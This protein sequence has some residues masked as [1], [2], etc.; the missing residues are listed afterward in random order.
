MVM[1]LRPL[2]KQKETGSSIRTAL[3]LSL[4]FG[5]NFG[6]MATPIG[7][8][9]NAI[10]I[11]AI[12]QQ[13]PLTFIQWMLIA[14]P[15]T[16][17][18]LILTFL[19]LKL[20]YPTSGQIQ[21]PALQLD[22][23]TYK[24]HVVVAIFFAAVLAWLLEPLHGVPAAIIAL[25]VAVLLFGS[26]LLNKSD[27]GKIDWATLLLIAGGLTLGE[28]LDRTGLVKAIAS[29]IQW[30]GVP[31]AVVLFM[32][33]FSTAFLSAIASNTAASVLFIQL[34]ADIDPSSYLPI[35]I[36]IG[37]S[38]GAPFVISTPPNTMVYGEGGI[39]STDFLVPGLIL[40][41]VGCI[42]VAWTG[43]D[44]LAMAGLFK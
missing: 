38:L 31:R 32:L 34:T 11:A 39:R 23:V 40:M 7:T 16:T 18:M 29:S 8:G 19:I 5:A 43:P 24:F 17:G 25:G 27:L 41:I 3:L 12:Q 28:L 13:H 10:A 35:L 15:L 30:H 22:P 20:R 1:V 4:A 21:L 14:L 6:G 37:A 26:G 44:I 33:I 2:W 42:V 36:A 9:P